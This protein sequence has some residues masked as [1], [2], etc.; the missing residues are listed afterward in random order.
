M[1]ERN[2]CIV[3]LHFVLALVQR[4]NPLA[5]A[6]KK[7]SQLL[8]RCPNVTTGASLHQ[9]VPSCHHDAPSRR[10]S[11]NVLTKIRM[12]PNIFYMIVGM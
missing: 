1:A 3:L 11:Q 8:K 4:L 10:R 12:T 6:A 7:I 2:L 5:N 9:P